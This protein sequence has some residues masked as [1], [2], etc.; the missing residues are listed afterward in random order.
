MRLDVVTLFPDLC[1][2]ILGESVIGRARE[3]GL[4]TVRCTNPRDFTTDRHRTV[5]DT[6]YGG[7]AGM[8]LKPEPLFAAV[9]QVAGPEAHVVLMSPQ[10]QPFCQETARRLARLPHLVL[11]CGHYEG[12]DERVRQ[13]LADEE[14]SLGD[15]V[16]TNGTLAAAV[17]AD[18]VIRLLPGVLGADE[19]SVDESFG[20][21]GWLE[22]PHYTRPPE[23]RG[24]RV[25]AVLLSG[26]HGA[27]ERWR[28]EQSLV[29]TAARRPDVLLRRYGDRA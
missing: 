5:D 3:R 19:S 27:I 14:L 7:G 24:M 22:Y 2:A 21:H 25:P 12:V 11:V 6:P 23:F 17:V 8:V 10:G 18:A 1:E 15:Y 20:P 28:R 29:R 16:L 4:V 13:S 26:D 9:E